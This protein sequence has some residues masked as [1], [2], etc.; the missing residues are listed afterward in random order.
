MTGINLACDVFVNNPPP[1]AL[2]I[3]LRRR[4]LS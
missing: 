3:S 1:R 4:N 2:T